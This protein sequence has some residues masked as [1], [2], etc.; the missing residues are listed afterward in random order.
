MIPL[1]TIASIK[2]FLPL[3]EVIASY[4]KHCKK[5]V[6]L[7]VD[8]PS[9]LLALTDS[10]DEKEEEDQGVLLRNWQNQL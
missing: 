7:N 8:P 4:N 5:Q 10:L 3:D 2:Y 1:A 9:A 6:S